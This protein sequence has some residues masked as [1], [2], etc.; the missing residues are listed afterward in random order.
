[1]P[2]E[3]TGNILVL[4]AAVAQMD[5]N[6]DFA[7]KYW[8]VLAKWAAYLKEKGF[9][10]ENQL[11][12]DDFAGHLAHNVNLS[13]KAICG[14]AS[15]ARL[16]E[17]RGEKAKADEF[18]ALA[19]KYAARWVAEANDGD[20]FRLAFDKPGSWSQK[21]NVVWDRILDFG[22]WPADALRKDMD[23]YKQ[24][25]NPYGLPLDNRKDYTKLDWTLWT[26]T[27]TQNRADFD[28]LCE[29]VYRFLNTTPNRSPMTDWY[30]TK[31]AQKVG[32]T[33]RPV[34]GGVFL[35]MLY[36]K[37]VWTKWAGRDRAKAA[38]WAPL[39][40]TAVAHPLI[41]TARE[42][43]NIHWQYTT[44]KPADDWF[45][46]GFA[47]AGWKRGVAGFGMPKTPGAV[48]RTPW[49]TDDIWLRHEFELIDLPAGQVALL[50]HHDED[51]EVF[52]NGVPAA[53]AG[54]YISDYETFDIAPA[55]KSALKIG[56]NLIAIHCHQT[57]GGQYIDAGLVRLEPAK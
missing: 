15:F 1:M 37:S 22:L 27:L 47:D 32:F 52:I 14:L 12:T 41:L 35:Q 6:A 19:K 30:Q 57:T 18:M 48:V 55:A 53:Q 50:M 42:D 3:E 40:K 38:N 29:P 45:K 9:D 33:A 16:C 49:K 25:Q 11:C 56:K 21:Y 20:H 17:L 2:V 43:K 28:A 34:V 8:S 7:A 39:P 24:S 26:A 31:T 13:A 36:D 23:F 54:G 5:G 4:L 10:P 46:P 51:A 44:Q